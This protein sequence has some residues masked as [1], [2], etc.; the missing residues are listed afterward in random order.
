MF[1]DVCHNACNLSSVPVAAGAFSSTYKQGLTATV[2]PQQ[3]ALKASTTKARV[4]VSR[5]LSKWL[6]ELWL[7]PLQ[8]TYWAADL[9]DG[10]SYLSSKVIFQF[11][12]IISTE[13]INLCSVSC[14]ILTIMYQDTP[15]VVSLHLFCVECNIH[16]TMFRWQAGVNCQ[17]HTF[18][19]GHDS[20]IAAS[21]SQHCSPHCASPCWPPAYM[22]R[23]FMH[24]SFSVQ[25]T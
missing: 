5:E 24:L 7:L 19:R 23:T 21:D 11:R 1:P 8:T 12:A 17:T 14:A 9:G 16:D 2:A 13:F 20:C 6:T 3:Q 15:Y 22:M 10:G 25:L 18:V 4:V